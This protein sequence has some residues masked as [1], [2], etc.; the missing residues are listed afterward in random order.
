MY[1]ILLIVAI[2]FIPFPIKLGFTY[3]NNKITVNIYN[4]KI[5]IDREKKKS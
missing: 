1:I 4:Y 5:N 2:I 3:I